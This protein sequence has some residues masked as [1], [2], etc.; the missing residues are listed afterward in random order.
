MFQIKFSAQ[1]REIKVFKA[2]LFSYAANFDSS[3]PKKRFMGRAVTNKEGGPLTKSA[4]EEKL[5]E[6][7][8]GREEHLES[9][10]LSKGRD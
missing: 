1:D 9:E 5:S 4:L 2:L 7:K 8:G 10:R 3:H 6:A